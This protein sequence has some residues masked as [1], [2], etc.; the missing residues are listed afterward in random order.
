MTPSDRYQ[1]LLDESAQIAIKSGRNPNEITLIAISKGVSIQNISSVYQTGCRNFGENRIQEAM[2]KMAEM[3]SD[4]LWHMIGNLQSNK[5]RK[6]INSF[7][8]IHSVDTPEMVNQISHCSNE[9][10]VQTRILL[11]VNTS[12]EPSKHGLTVESWRETFPSLLGLSG[13]RIEGLMTMAPY[14]AEEAI[15]RG[16]F[17]RLRLLGQEFSLPHLSMGMSHDYRWAI[18]EGATMLRIG[19]AIFEGG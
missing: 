11:E 5:V 16:C 18:Q 19:T 6:A 12:G 2:P 9:M 3:P 17:S 4:I 15:V 1:Q 14:I 10:G 13:I 8:L 7:A